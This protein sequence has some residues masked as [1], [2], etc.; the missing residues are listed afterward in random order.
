M[1][2]LALHSK[3]TNHRHDRM[4]NFLKSELSRTRSE[5]KAWVS[6][7][8]KVWNYRR[9]VLP[10]SSAGEL[11]SA[12]DALRDDIKSK[13]DLPRLKTSIEKLERILSK[14][15]GVYYP[16][17]SWQD[18]L[19]FF[20]YAAIFVIGLRVFVAQPF[21][22][23]TNSMW[24][25]YYGMTAEMFPTRAEEP[26]LP[27]QAVRLAAFGARPRRVDATADGRVMI[28]AG[29]RPEPDPATGQRVVL[30]PER[31]QGRNWGV[32]PANHALWPMRVG[33]SLTSV[34][35]PA[36]FAG[37]MY[38]LY[39][40]AFFPSSANLEEGVLAAIRNRRA[41]P[42]Q[43][44]ATLERG[45]GLF[46][47]ETEKQVRRGERI[48]AFDILGGDQ[49]FVDRISYHFRR[50][51]VGDSFVF[52]TGNIPRIGADQYY[53]KRLVGV[54]GDTL[55]VQK[56]VLMRN[57][58]PIEG[59]R[60]FDLNARQAEH[61]AGYTDFWAM[62]NGRSVVVPRDHFYAMGDNS[63][64]S[65]DSRNWGGVPARDVVGKPLFIYYPF[66]RRW[67]HAP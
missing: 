22:I 50:P 25:S 18:N 16:R 21:K 60:A 14:T 66:T 48:L 46:W 5:A 17:S 9:D 63:P 54:G 41:I 38:S 13:V 53:I 32:F 55:A 65:S 44:G 33:D 4:F 2:R 57:G 28:L 7:G 34:S 8:K 30:Q 19:E 43:Q 20:F 1:Q 49:L 62:S 27:L 23:P 12:T 52:R 35:T 47:V 39:H 10:E 64:Q 56:P 59:S 26:S 58:S 40:E 24:P 11:R 31:V 36:E 15:G 61:F 37:E 42:A 67:L 3:I 6:L 51:Q 45:V 29:V